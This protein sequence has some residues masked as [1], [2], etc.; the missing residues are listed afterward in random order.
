MDFHKDFML[1]VYDQYGG[2]TNIPVMHLALILA[3]P[4]CYTMLTRCSLTRCTSVVFYG[5]IY[6]FTWSM[7]LHNIDK[8]ISTHICSSWIS[9]T[10]FS[11]VCGLYRSRYRQMLTRVGLL[12]PSPRSWWTNSSSPPCW[13]QRCRNSSMCLGSTAASLHWVS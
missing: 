2:Q 8:L 1:S 10:S 11:D 13:R 4:M 6:M 5:V 9:R 7:R 3:S 12:V